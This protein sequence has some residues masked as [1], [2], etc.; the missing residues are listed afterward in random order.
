MEKITEIF[1]RKK[2]NWKRF[3]EDKR[4]EKRVL[5]CWPVR[6]AAG[7]DRVRLSVRPRSNPVRPG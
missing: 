7:P 4:E 1:G 6:P 5:L 2:G 3:I